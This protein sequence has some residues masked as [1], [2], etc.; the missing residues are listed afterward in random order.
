MEFPSSCQTFGNQYYEKTKQRKEPPKLQYH[1]KGPRIVYGSVQVRIQNQPVRNDLR[2]FRS[3]ANTKYQTH[4]HTLCLMMVE[5][6]PE[7]SRKNT[8]IQDMINSET[9]LKISAKVRVCY[10]GQN[11]KMTKDS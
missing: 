9:I 6:S 5:V 4:T 3:S 10:F 11:L 1:R 8:M 2:I 7:T